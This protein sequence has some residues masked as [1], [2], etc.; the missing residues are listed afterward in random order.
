MRASGRTSVA[1]ALTATATALTLLGVVL[2]AAQ[3]TWLTGP[4]REAVEGTGSA[5]P[6][7]YVL[8]CALAAPLHLCGLLGALSTVTFGL[9]EALGLTFVGT[10]LGGVLTYLALV[11]LRLPVAQHPATWPVWLGRL[12]AGVARRPVPVGLVARLALGSGAAL[13]AFFLLTG[14]AWRT[15]LLCAVLGTA[16]WSAQAILGVT[17]LRELSTVSG[18]WALGFAALPLLM[19]AGLAALRARRRAG[20]GPA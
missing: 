16:L 5:A 19:V 3:P 8:L 4:L 10:L 20:A 7:V 15:Y 12:A 14:Y 17:A 6:V 9:G 1:G 2:A 13:E 18:A 11:R